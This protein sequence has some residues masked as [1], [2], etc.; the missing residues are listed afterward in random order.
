[1]LL[2]K[3]KV[4]RIPTATIQLNLGQSPP[5]YNESPKRAYS[6]SPQK[7]RE[8]T[9]S[10]TT[11]DLIQSI[12]DH[13]KP[14]YATKPNINWRT[15]IGIAANDFKNALKKKLLP[16]EKPIDLNL[17]ESPQTNENIKKSSGGKIIVKPLNKPINKPLNKPPNKPNKPHNK[18]LNK[19]RNKPSKPRNNPK[20]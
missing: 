9:K 13:Y 19:P 10:Y 6:I 18:P 14:V 20:K 12:N 4:K 17:G 2:F 7:Q 3:K 5:L 11:H 16:K 8:Q 15:R 1:M